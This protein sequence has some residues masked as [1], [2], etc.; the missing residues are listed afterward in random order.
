MQT[1]IFL[2]QLIFLE[3]IG[4][5]HFCLLKIG[6]SG[7]IFLSPVCLANFEMNIS[8]GIYC[9]VQGIAEKG[10]GKG[11]IVFWFISFYFL[12]LF[13]QGIKLISC[14]LVG[15]SGYFLLDLQGFSVVVGKMLEDPF[16]D[17]FAFTNV[18]NFSCRIMQIIDP[19]NT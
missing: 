12:I 5:Y 3:N 18:N 11:F 7:N 4:Q 19:G 10:S 2:A 17:V 13:K 1:G 6:E 9:S 14:G 16:L 8:V 15:Y